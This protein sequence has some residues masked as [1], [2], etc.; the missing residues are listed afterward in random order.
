MLMAD[1]LS[2]FVELAISLR[3]WHHE[4]G[5]ERRKRIDAERKELLD[6]EGRISRVDRRGVAARRDERAIRRDERRDHEQKDRAQH[7]RE[8]S[9][10]GS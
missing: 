2:K 4:R 7:R 10:A 6:E 1:M 9:D 8:K 5:V 3:R